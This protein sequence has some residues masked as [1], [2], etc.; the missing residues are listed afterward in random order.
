MVLYRLMRSPQRPGRYVLLA[1]G[2]S[3]LAVAGAVAG[4]AAS[5]HHMGLLNN[6]AAD[7]VGVAL[8][9]LLA[10][11]VT[12][13]TTQVRIPSLARQLAAMAQAMNAGQAV[14]GRF[15]AGLR[16]LMPGSPLTRWKYGRVLITPQSVVWVRR[17]TGRARDLTGARCTGER[18]PDRGYTEMTL[19]L[20]SSY[21]GENI[22]IITLRANGRDVE[23]AAPA[24][25]LEIIRYSLGRTSLR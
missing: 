9:L 18:R 2:F 22:R 3:A 23:L 7:L 17:V 21:R 24:R 12:A 1:V 25:L 13:Y 20:P 15:G 16:D 8:A 6:L 11:L 14:S 10:T 4:T 19:S 5:A